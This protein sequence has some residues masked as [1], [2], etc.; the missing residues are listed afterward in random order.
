M[1]DYDPFAGTLNNNQ[2]G[3]DDPFKGTIS[4]DPIPKS[5]NILQKA[6]QGINPNAVAYSMAGGTAPTDI[7]GFL[8]SKFMGQPQAVQSPMVQS[9]GM[10]QEGLNTVQ[11]PLLKGALDIGSNPMTYAGLG[12][13]GE[14]TGNAAENIMNPSKF[15]GKKMAEMAT[16][17][18]EGK[19]D[20]LPHIMNAI[21]DPVAGKL[22]D[23]AKILER[24]GGTSLGE[25]GAVSEKLSNLSPQDSQE[26]V[27]AL[28]SE[29]TKAVKE[30]TLKP[31]ELGVGKLLGNLSQAQNEAFE[32]F[33]S[34]KFGYGLGKNTQ[35]LAKGALKTALLGG[36]FKA[37]SDL[38]GPTIKHLF[39]L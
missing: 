24:F 39:G 9:E 4:T 34:A 7:G 3:G 27:N 28:K 31:K 2:S 21:D 6:I 15:Y 19:V 38:I 5:E 12:A 17:N 13:A 14:A 30:G 35:K 37:G 11:N 32:G 26:V 23:K 10:R 8:A 29:V 1:A 36:E 16:S 22:I 25:G 20:F 18:P 33:K